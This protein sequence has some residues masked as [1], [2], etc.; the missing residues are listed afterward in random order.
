MSPSRL[1]INCKPRIY[2]DLFRSIFQSLARVE[3]VEIAPQRSQS[4]QG[5]DEEVE[6]DVIV[7]SLNV[8]GQ[9]ESDL[10]NGLLQKAKVIAFSPEGDFALRRL[11]GRCDW[12]EI[13]P[14]GLDQLIQEV[15]GVSSPGQTFSP[16]L[17]STL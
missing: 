4:I 1:L 12:E 13:R 10:A 3:I 7:L 6:V 14:F 17:D 11:P 9:P 5:S 2:A 16:N 15:T 8:H